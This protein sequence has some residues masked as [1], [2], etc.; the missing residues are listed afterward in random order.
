MC[1]QEQTGTNTTVP[2]LPF[3]VLAPPGVPTTVRLLVNN[4]GDAPINDSTATVSP[5]DESAISAT[6]VPSATNIPNVVQQ[7]AI[8]PLVLIGPT[9]KGV[10]FIPVNGSA[11]V[12]VTIVPSFYVRGT[13]E[14]LFVNLEYNNVVGQDTNLTLPIGVEILPVT[15]Q[16]A[17]HN[18]LQVPTSVTHNPI[19]VSDDLSNTVLSAVT[20]N[21]V[22]KSNNAA[23]HGAD[24]GVNNAAN[25]AAN[26][27]A[28]A[29]SAAHSASNNA[30][31]SAA[32]GSSISGSSGR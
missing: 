1:C 12:D 18:A 22:A 25:S 5:R 8:Q 17:L 30:A 23:N 14:N 2:T 26:N 13:V 28:S 4:T 3:L 11:E 19:H 24:N 27:A 9:R 10:G 6:V 32:H 29:T 21:G 20:S 31:S 7:N 16:T 15:A